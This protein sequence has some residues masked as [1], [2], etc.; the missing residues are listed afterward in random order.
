MTI[1]YRDNTTVDYLINNQ[2]IIEVKFKTSFTKGFK[3]LVLDEF[4]KI[5]KVKRFN[6]S[7]VDFCQRFLATNLPLIRKLARRML[8]GRKG[9]TYGNFG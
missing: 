6:P 7:E 2:G 9:D 3:S 8:K 4:G 5:I 1:C